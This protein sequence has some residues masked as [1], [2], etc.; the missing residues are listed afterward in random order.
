MEEVDLV[1]AEAVVGVVVAVVLIV[2][3]G[4]LRWRS[5]RNVE[6]VIAEPPPPPTACVIEGVQGRRLLEQVKSLI[7]QLEPAAKFGSSA[8]VGQA[9]EVGDGGSIRGAL[10]ECARD[11]ARSVETAEEPTRGSLEGL[12]LTQRAARDISNRIEQRRRKEYRAGLEYFRG[13]LRRLTADA[14]MEGYR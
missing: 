9:A 13:A 12:G 6:A 5:N 3:M 14:T 10:E 2:V 8:L 4:V 11:W 1:I 7:A